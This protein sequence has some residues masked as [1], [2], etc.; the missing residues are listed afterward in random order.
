[1][2]CFHTGL[3]NK[4]ASETGSA[5]I[6]ILVA[7]AL[8]AALTASFMRPSSQQT[9]AQQGFKAVSSLQS[10]I[11]FIRSSVQECVLTY[12]DGEDGLRGKTGFSFPFPLNPSSTYFSSPSGDDTIKHVRCPGNPGGASPDH[13]PI[14]SGASGKFMPPPP[15]LFEE[16]IYYNGVDGVFFYTQ[17][18][19]TDAFLETAMLKLDENFSECEADVIDA[20]SGEVELTSTAATNDPKCSDNSRCFRVWMIIQGSATYPG[21]T[22]GEETAAGC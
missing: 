16:W 9:T 21:D 3:E 7:I 15:D 20:T 12:P 10:Q 13:A 19:K 11:Q 14:F 4:G 22:D 8:L 18:D 5:F 6:Y 1:M 17:T 2:P